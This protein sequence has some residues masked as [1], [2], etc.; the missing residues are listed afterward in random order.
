MPDV[1]ARARVG[2]KSRPQSGPGVRRAPLPV[3]VARGPRDA[4]AV[5]PRL[6]PLPPDDC[7]VDGGRRQRHD[8]GTTPA[9]APD[10]LDYAILATDPYPLP[11]VLPTRGSPR[12]ALGRPASPSI[13]RDDPRP[14]P[15]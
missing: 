9:S 5:R 12:P 11:V 8:R 6:S 3:R 1:P 4:I 10:E 14:R 15:A 13:R 2:H 7:R